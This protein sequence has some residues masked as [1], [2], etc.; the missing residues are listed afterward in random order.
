MKRTTEA[1]FETVIEAHLLKNGYV[2]I[3]G[4]AFDCE[5]AIFPDEALAFIRETQPNEWA[6]LERLHGD[7]T[8]EQVLGDLCKWMDQHGAHS[9]DADHPFRCDADH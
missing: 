8:G 9:S 1:A 3:A 2:R 5:R 6:R 4:D 7:R